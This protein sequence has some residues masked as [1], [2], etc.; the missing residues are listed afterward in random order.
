MLQ[1]KAWLPILL[2]HKFIPTTYDNNCGRI[3][4]L[5]DGLFFSFRSY[6]SQVTQVTI[7][8]A[9]LVIASALCC[10]CSALPPLSSG[11]DIKEYC[12]WETFNASCPAPDHVIVMMSARYGRMAESRCVTHCCWINDSFCPTA[13]DVAPCLFSWLFIP[14]NVIIHARCTMCPWII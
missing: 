13:L 4:H 8:N 3:M 9:P 2:I 1:T 6:S 11:S 5:T 7:N 10:R 12:Q 14:P